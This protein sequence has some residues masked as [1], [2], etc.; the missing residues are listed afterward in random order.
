V[1]AGRVLVIRLVST[2]EHNTVIIRK[3]RGTEARR[4]AEIHTVA[5]PG[6]TLSKLGKLFLRVYYHGICDDADGIALV[7]ERNG[8]ILGFATGMMNPS[9][10]YARLLKRRWFRFMVAAVPGAIR[11][12][13]FIPRLFG[14][15]WLP[16]SSPVG[17]TI[18]TLSSIAVSPEVA[19][20][21]IGRR[22]MEEFV[23]EVKRRGGTE[24]TWGAK[25]RDEIANRFYQRIGYSE[26]REHV[27]SQGEGVIE[28]VFRF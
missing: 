22:L 9:G 3:M 19:G 7:G 2:M 27:D 11:H 10:F 6:Y 25:K 4:V 26:T 1:T 5:F 17:G 12:P 24:L 8:T 21:G 18:A 15:L 14:A 23:A 20:C 16:Q 13:G 28:Y